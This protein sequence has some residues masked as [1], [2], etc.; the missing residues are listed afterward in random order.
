MDDVRI[1]DMKG[2]LTGPEVEAMMYAAGYEAE[3]LYKAIA[4]VS[5]TA[6]VDSTVVD[7]EVTKPYGRGAPRL[8]ATLLVEAPHAAAVEFGYTTKSGVKVPGQHP[9]LKVL[10][11]MSI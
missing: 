4:P 11:A 1:H 6:L 10:R 9:L 3:A 7:V 2:Y 5:S 8:T